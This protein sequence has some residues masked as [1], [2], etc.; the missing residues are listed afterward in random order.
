LKLREGVEESLIR[1]EGVRMRTS[2]G[3]DRKQG[4]G[5]GGAGGVEHAQPPRTP[6]M[7]L[8]QGSQAG[9]AQPAEQ[10]SDQV[11][12]P[13]QGSQTGQEGRKGPETY[14]CTVCREKRERF[15]IKFFGVCADRHE[16]LRGLLWDLRGLSQEEIDSIFTLLRQVKDFLLDYSR[17]QRGEIARGIIELLPHFKGLGPELVKEAI[18]KVMREL[19]QN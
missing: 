7:P 16:D 4:E 19:A 8:A 5:A 6:E 10:P 18:E 11:Q 1:D 9:G 15:N 17:E 3:E 13:A 2:E 12:P 14:T